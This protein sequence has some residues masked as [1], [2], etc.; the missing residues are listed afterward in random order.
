MGRLTEVEMYEAGQLG[1]RRTIKSRARFLD[2]GKHGEHP[3][4]WE[5]DILGAMAEKAVAKGLGVYCEPTVNT[6]HAPDVGPLQ[7]RSTCYPNGKLIIRPGDP[8]GN[9]VLVITRPPVFRIAGVYQFSGQGQ[10]EHLSQPDQT[11]PTCWAIPQ[12]E[13]KDIHS[14]QKN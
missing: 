4:Q 8:P 3:N 7:V 13:L 1:L 6:F 12:D 11:R 5:I 14:L 2:T 10:P 9:Y